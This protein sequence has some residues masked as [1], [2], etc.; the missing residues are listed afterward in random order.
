MEQVEAEY[1]RKQEPNSLIGRVERL[2]VSVTRLMGSQ[3]KL[4]MSSRLFLLI[5]GE[6]GEWGYAKG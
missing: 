3:R 1:V 6:C 4:R 2:A 5:G